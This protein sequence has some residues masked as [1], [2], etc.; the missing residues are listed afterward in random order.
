MEMRSTRGLYRAAPASRGLLSNASEA[1]HANMLKMKKKG[2][3]RQSSSVAEQCVL[4]NAVCSRER[5]FQEK[6]VDY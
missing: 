5:K 4:I 2:V 6:R 3:L 1:V